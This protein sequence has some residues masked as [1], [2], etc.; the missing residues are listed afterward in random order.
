M[1]GSALRAWAGQLGAAA[2]LCAGHKLSV[3]R[4]MLMSVGWRRKGV[5]MLQVT[6]Y[7]LF[8]YILYT[9]SYLVSFFDLVVTL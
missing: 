2:D 9:Y 5:H 3:D 7:I 6:F 1:A 8:K 4:R